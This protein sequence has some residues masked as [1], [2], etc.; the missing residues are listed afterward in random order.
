M[1]ISRPEVA[2]AW[3]PKLRGPSRSIPANARFYFTELGWE[4]VGRHVVAAAQRSGQRYRIIS[5]K[6]SAVHV[7]WRDRLEVA[8]QPKKEVGMT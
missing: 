6:H 8:A 1:G 7:V 3:V 2:E 4:K 5:V